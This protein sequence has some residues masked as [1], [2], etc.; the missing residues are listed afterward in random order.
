MIANSFNRQFTTSKLRKHSL[1]RRTRQVSKD[2]KRMS[3]EEAESFT[4]R[5]GQHGFRPR[6]STTSALLHLTTYIDAGFNQ[7]KP[8]HHT[9]YE[10]IDLTAAFDT[11]SRDI[12]ISKFA[13]SSLPPA[14]TR[15]LSCYLRWRQVAT[16]FRGTKSSTR[17]VRTGV[18]QG[19]K[20]SLLH[21]WYAKA[22]SPVKRV[23]YADDIIVWASRPKIPLLESMI[24]S[25]LREVGIYLKENS[26]LKTS[27]K[28][29]TL[30]VI[31]I[32]L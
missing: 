5:P 9:M 1:S 12:L 28:V 30:L 11:V 8:P 27:C 21:S 31:F 18:P 14:I 29:K 19:C 22:V 4:Q 6:H 26:L 25:Y 23:C 2:V 20:L 17:I 13:W 10:T 15:W 32:F 7:Q 16:S 3:L 24:N